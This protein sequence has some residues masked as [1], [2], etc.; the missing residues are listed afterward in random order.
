M[1]SYFC[2]MNSLEGGTVLIKG[3]SWRVFLRSFLVEIMWNYPRMQ[4]I[5]FT[6]CLL[7]ALDKLFPDAQHRK[8][9]IERQIE[10]GNTNPAFGPMCV[11]AISKLEEEDC[12]ENTREIRKRLMSTLAAQGDRIF[13][14]MLRP[15]SSLVAV[16]VAMVFSS[17][18]WAPVIGLL[19]YNVPNIFIRY[20][21]FQ[22]G[23]DGGVNV[24]RK[25]KSRW[26]EESI[27][28][29]RG[30]VFLCSG[31]LTAVS[32]IL[33]VKHTGAESVSGVLALLILVSVIF[34]VCFLVLKNSFS[35]TRI[36]YPLII[37][38]LLGF[39]LLQ[40]WT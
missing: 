25:F 14:G 19:V 17:S 27:S 12:P 39:S 37:F 16:V 13:W 34:A 24:V 5:G 15:V 40:K 22:A 29:L 4:N 2:V 36:I 30:L 3:V 18:F 38:M 6:F 7:P 31:C 26:V 33:A 8:E 10:Y 35:Q 28:V 20:T 23:Y 1:V 9:A 21:G 11:G 32:L